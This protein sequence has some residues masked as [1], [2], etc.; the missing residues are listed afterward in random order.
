MYFNVYKLVHMNLFYLEFVFLENK[1]QS[2]INNIYLFK[3][4]YL[5]R[6]DFNA[7]KINNLIVSKEEKK[8]K[9]HI[10]KTTFNINILQCFKLFFCAIN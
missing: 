10:N 1:S 3:F 6:Y 2:R 7:I 8:I 5:V 9:S 4:I